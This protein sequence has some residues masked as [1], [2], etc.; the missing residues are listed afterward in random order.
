MLDMRR[1]WEYLAQGRW[2]RWVIRKGR[3]CWAVNPIIWAL[4]SLASK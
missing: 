4:P 1:V 3:L 2:V